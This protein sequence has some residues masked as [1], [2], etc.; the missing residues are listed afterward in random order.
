[1]CK[2][3]SSCNSVKAVK[4]SRHLYSLAG[5]EC[6]AGVEVMGSTLG[7]TKILVIR[8]LLQNGGDSGFCS[9][10]EGRL[11]RPRSTCVP[12]IP[13]SRDNEVSWLLVPSH[14]QRA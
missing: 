7:G 1:M 11:R 3:L 4:M 13:T 2:V 12:T 10:G 9:A 8:D 5:K 6:N 14:P